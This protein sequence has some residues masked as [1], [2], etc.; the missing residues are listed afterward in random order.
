MRFVYLHALV[1][2]CGWS[3]F[4]QSP[5]PTL[6]LVVSLEAIFLSTFVMIGQNRCGRLQQ[7]KADSDYTTVDQLPRRT[8]ASPGS[9]P[10]TSEVH[11]ALTQPHW[12]PTTTTDADDAYDSAGRRPV[13][14]RRSA[15]ADVNVIQPSAHPRRHSGST[16]RGHV[17]YTSKERTC[18]QEG[19][20]VERGAGIE[21][22]LIAQPCAVT[23]NEGLNRWAVRSLFTVAK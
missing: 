4:E 8:L 2:R 23:G 9:P 18:I 22:Q 3:Y 1:S 19:A 17:A 20:V 7:A 15:R 14:R 12:A 13:D 21:R 5:W 11:E 6:T 16:G 10:L